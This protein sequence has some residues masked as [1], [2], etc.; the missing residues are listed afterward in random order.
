MIKTS[1]PGDKGVQAFQAIYKRTAHQLTT[2]TY[3]HI[4]YIAGK[5]LLQKWGRSKCLKIV[6]DIEAK[7][8]SDKA[9]QSLTAL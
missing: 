9:F 1:F 7:M 3:I 6:T 8:C 5:I 4:N 2:H